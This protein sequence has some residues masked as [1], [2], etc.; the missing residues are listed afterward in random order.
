MK[1]NFDD[2][3]ETVY[4]RFRDDYIPDDKQFAYFELIEIINI[5]DKYSLEAERKHI[6]F[7]WNGEI[8][9]SSDYIEMG[10]E[11][12]N[13]GWN[14]IDFFHEERIMFRK[15]IEELFKK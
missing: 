13:N 3:R 7:L 9:Y 2:I 5:T 10:K 4:Y 15:A 14:D 11:T 8:E 12:W 6:Y 1:L